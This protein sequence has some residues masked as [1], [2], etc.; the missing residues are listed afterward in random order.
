MTPIP[1]LNEDLLFAVLTLEAI[2]LLPIL[3]AT[4]LAPG[5]KERELKAALAQALTRN[6]EL[7]RKV[8]EL[9]DL[10]R[11]LQ[12][13]IKEREEEMERRL[14]KEVSKIKEEC[15]RRLRE[16]TKVSKTALT[17]LNA[18]M[19][20]AVK[21]IDKRNEC[22]SVILEPTQILCKERGR[23]LKV[24]WPEERVAGEEEVYV[25]AEGG[26]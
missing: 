4:V 14:Q 11:G 8:R 22:V 26:E 20:G 1:F 9:E 24:L 3:S 15:D 5:R 16:A 21:V 10:N 13:Q 12:K 7:E 2:V 19:A 17:L 23:T 6:E 25:E 18:V